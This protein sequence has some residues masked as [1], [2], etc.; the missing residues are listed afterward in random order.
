M[1]KPKAAP[2]Q[3]LSPGEASKAL[4][5]SSRTLNRWRL[6]GNGPRYYVIEGI[7]RYSRK[8]IDSWLDEKA[9]EPTGRMKS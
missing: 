2:Q 6:N 8:D 9:V 3:L 4:A 7:V 1:P 5:V